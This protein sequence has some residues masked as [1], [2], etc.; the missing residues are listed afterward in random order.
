[1]DLPDETTTDLQRRLR[2]VEGQV[3]GIHQMLET[4]RDCRE[5]VPQVS[6]ATKALEQIGFLLVAAGLRYCLSDPEA[7]GAEGYDLEAVQKMF[8][9]LA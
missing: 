2:R 7:S 6:A 3:R 1:M 9:R 8:L 4:G 5:V